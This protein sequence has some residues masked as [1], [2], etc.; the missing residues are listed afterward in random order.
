VYV[1][2]WHAVVFS[3]IFITLALHYYVPERMF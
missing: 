2:R 3:E 1:I